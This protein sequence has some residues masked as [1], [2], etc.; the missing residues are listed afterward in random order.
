MP[1]QAWR[2][3]SWQDAW[4]VL[5]PRFLLHWWPGIKRE[6]LKGSQTPGLRWIVPWDLVE[7]FSS[8]PTYLLHSTLTDLLQLSVK[9]AFGWWKAKDREL[10]YSNSLTGL[11]LRTKELKNSALNFGW[12][13]NYPACPLGLLQSCKQSKGNGQCLCYVRGVSYLVSC[14]LYLCHLPVIPKYPLKP[15]WPLTIRH[16]VLLQ[17]CEVQGTRHCNEDTSA[18]SPPSVTPYK[19]PSML[20]ELY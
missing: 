19:R 18:L 4:I 8:G 10:N 1:R 7:Q 17:H 9:M 14:I 20:S 11:E 12:K 16:W 15:W 5:W 13:T 6:E 3:A 2:F